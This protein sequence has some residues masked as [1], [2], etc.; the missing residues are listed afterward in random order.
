MLKEDYEKFLKEN[1]GKGKKKVKSATSAAG[2]ESIDSTTA[3]NGSENVKKKRRRQKKGSSLSTVVADTIEET[4]TDKKQLVAD[5]KATTKEVKE[6]EVVESTP[7][8][9]VSIADISASIDS[10]VVSKRKKRKRKKGKSANTSFNVPT[11]EG[12]S[13]ARLSSYGVV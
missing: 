1:E 7:A 8:Q 13:A 6:K 3:A 2:S 4:N 9:Q 5:P 12:V 11:L 10:G